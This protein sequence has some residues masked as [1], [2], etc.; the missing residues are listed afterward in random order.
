M[1]EDSELR[2][3]K[4]QFWKRYRLRFPADVRPSDSVVSRVSRELSKRMLCVFSV[5]K[6]RS[7]QFQMGS[8][9]RKRKL[10]EGLFTEEADTEEVV[11]HDCDTY[12]QKLHTH[13]RVCVGGSPAAGMGDPTKEFVSGANLAEFVEAP[14]DVLLQYY[15][16]ARKAVHRLPAGKRLA[17]LQHRDSE[18]AEWVTR[19]QES[20][21]SLGSVLT[22]LMET[23]DVIGY[24]QPTA[25][26][27]TPHAAPSQP[28]PKEP[29][30]MNSQ[31]LAG[32]VIS[33]K[34]TAQLRRSL[35]GASVRQ[36]RRPHQK[37]S[38]DLGDGRPMPK[39]FSSNQHPENLPGLPV[40]DQA[41]VS[42]TT[43]YV[44]SS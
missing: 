36:R 17:W 18:R 40:K 42:G 9:Q 30:Q 31:F 7:L 13:D 16:R 28:A 11:S 22:E 14:L 21:R 44:T 2:D 3:V 35:D 24:H 32:P 25:E 20:T 26:A 19:Y 27:P 23:R 33:G 6:V 34:P 1:L 41:R 43:W 15:F 12:L 8:S 5:W 4:T 29:A 39:P 10:G 37:K 38:R